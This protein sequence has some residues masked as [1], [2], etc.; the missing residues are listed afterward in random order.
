MKVVHIKFEPYDIYIGRPTKWGNPYS[1]KNG[2]L[3]KFK[4]DSIEEAV[5]KYEEYLLNDI[6]LLK[7]LPELKNKVLGCWC[8]LPNNPKPCHGDVLLRL[9]NI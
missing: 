6:E 7:D 5:V 9:A 4:V 1:H 8:K 3:A 2:T